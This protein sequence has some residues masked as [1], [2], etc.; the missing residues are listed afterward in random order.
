MAMTRLYTFTFTVE[1]GSNGIPDL[2]RAEEMI[3]LNMQELI[4]DDEFVA[5]LDEKESLTIQV[6]LVK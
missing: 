1:C 6:N 3:N 5:A 2:I 4:Y